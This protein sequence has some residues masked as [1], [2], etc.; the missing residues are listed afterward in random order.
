MVRG[1]VYLVNLAPRSGSEQT[2]VR[3]CVLVSHDSFN[4]TDAWRS[5]TIVPITSSPRWTRETPTTVVF[6][7]G[8]AGLTKPCAA[9]AHQ[10]TTVDRAK[11][12]RPALGRLSAKRMAALTQAIVNYLD[13]AS[14]PDS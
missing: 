13:L 6:E 10:V 12:V 1:E 5:V 11:L 8:E 3:P 9:L 2:G 7:S 4:T 14:S